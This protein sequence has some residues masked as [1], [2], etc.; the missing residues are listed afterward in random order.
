MIIGPNFLLGIN[1]FIYSVVFYRTR[2]VPLKLAALG[3]FG[4]ATIFLAAILEMCQFTMQFFATGAVLALPVFAFEMTLATRLVVKGL[5]EKS[6]I[7]K[8]KNFC[9]EELFGIGA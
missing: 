5:N 2:L 8:P 1:T 4:A 9:E 3:I 7:L 6:T